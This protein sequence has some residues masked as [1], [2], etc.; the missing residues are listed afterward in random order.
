M[1]KFPNTN[2]VNF[3]YCILL[4]NSWH[5]FPLWYFQNIFSQVDFLANFEYF[6]ETRVEIG[7]NPYINTCFISFA[8]VIQSKACQYYCW[9][10]FKLD[11]NFLIQNTR[12]S[13]Q[14]ATGTFN[15]VLGFCQ[16]MLD[17]QDSSP[18]IQNKV[19]G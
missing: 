8:K 16:H 14:T 11:V 5:G 19:S 10:T 18:F 3:D 15:R 17:L 13:F 12:S 2:L 1:S 6:S 7:K 4:T 9:N